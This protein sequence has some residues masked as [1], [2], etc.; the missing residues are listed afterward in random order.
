MN[1]PWLSLLASAVVGPNGYSVIAA[2]KA[3]SD[4]PATHAAL[5][6]ALGNLGLTLLAALAAG[7]AVDHAHR[8]TRSRPR[9]A[10]PSKKHAHAAAS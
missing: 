6:T 3:W 1:K 5:M 8:S 9:P 10:K 7:L 4:D 2:L